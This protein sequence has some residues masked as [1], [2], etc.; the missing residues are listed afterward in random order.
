MSR[1][2]KDK[3]KRTFKVRAHVP[4]VQKPAIESWE[5]VIAELKA[6]TASV[7]SR[8]N[9]EET[10]HF[11]MM[12]KTP[13]EA[14]Q[15][16]RNIATGKMSLQ[17][18]AGYDWQAVNIPLKG[19]DAQAPRPETEEQVLGIPVTRVDLPCEECRS[20]AYPNLRYSLVGISGV[21]CRTC[22]ETVIGQVNIALQ[23]T[24][25]RSPRGCERCGQS[26]PVKRV[27]LADGSQS[28]LLC[29]ECINEVISENTAFQVSSQE[30]IPYEV[31]R[32]VPIFLYQ[33][34]GMRPNH[35]GA[36]VKRYGRL[37]PA[38]VEDWQEPTL[39]NILVAARG[40]IDLLLTVQ[41]QGHVG[42]DG[43]LK[44]EGQE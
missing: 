29:E 38:H 13:T 32:E 10:V 39:D 11:F 14:A 33:D 12:N 15:V 41:E 42:K 16:V 9:K 37:E 1:H 36:M 3:H 7:G 23:S 43:Y 21:L 44:T 19:K 8:I 40:L 28:S 27:S 26:R 31:Y 4:P 34:E 17:D 25:E 20:T 24:G 18:I 35:Y 22:L 30:P 2:N 6:G 5:V